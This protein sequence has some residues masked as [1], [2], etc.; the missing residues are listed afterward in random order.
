MNA[1]WKKDNRQLSVIIML[2]LLK[3]LKENQKAID[4][5]YNLM[6]D[7]RLRSIKHP[8]LSDNKF[9]IKRVLE[10]KKIVGSFVK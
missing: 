7:N 10:G 9:K 2:R 3:R 1:M 6:I 8:I 5:F 4:Y